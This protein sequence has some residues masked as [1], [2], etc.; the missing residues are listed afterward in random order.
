MEEKMKQGKNIMQMRVPAIGSNQQF[1][2]NQVMQRKCT[3]GF[4]CFKKSFRVGIISKFA[5]G[6]KTNQDIIIEVPVYFCHSCGLE[7]SLK[8]NKEDDS[9]NERP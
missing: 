9:N 7:L 6:N 3:C 8:I 5:T 2:A 4:E 1:D